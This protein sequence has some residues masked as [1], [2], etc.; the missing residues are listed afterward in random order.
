MGAA[1][2]PKMAERQRY[3][4]MGDTPDDEVRVIIDK[5]TGPGGPM[6][7]DEFFSAHPMLKHLMDGTQEALSIGGPAPDGIVYQLT[8]EKSSLGEL[9]SA[10]GTK[11]L[12]LNFGSYT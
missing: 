2:S 9:F 12:L 10:S 5:I 7:P 4:E 1:V 3:S 8:G 6:P 11:P